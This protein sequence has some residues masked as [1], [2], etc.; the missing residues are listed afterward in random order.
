MEGGYCITLRPSIRPSDLNNY[1]SFGRNYSLD[2]EQI[3]EIIEQIC[4]T[5][6]W[7]WFYSKKQYS[8]SSEDPKFEIRCTHAR[9]NGH[10]NNAC[11]GVVEICSGMGATNFNF[12]ASADFS[13][14]TNTDSPKADQAFSTGE[15]YHLQFHGTRA[16]Y[17]RSIHTPYPSYPHIICPGS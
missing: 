2:L 16:W 8:L 1:K 17:S 5:I 10:P 4:E 11:I 15:D 3:S 13:R 12:M 6:A 7:I 14:L 9:T